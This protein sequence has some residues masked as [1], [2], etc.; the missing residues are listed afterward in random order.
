MPSAHVMHQRGSNLF[1]SC[2]SCSQ[3]VPLRLF[4]S[5]EEQPMAIACPHCQQEY[6]FSDPDLLRQLRKFEALCRQIQLSEEILGITSIGVDVGPHQVKIPFK[7]LLTRFN[8]HL[9]LR[10]GDKDLAIVFRQ[11]PASM[12]E[13]PLV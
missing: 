13:G 2:T 8:A 11:E 1:F 3:T 7:L 6:S 5:G 4:G 12:S 10:I 9:K